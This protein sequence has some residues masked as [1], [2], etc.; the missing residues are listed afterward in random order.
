MGLSA[1]QTRLLHYVLQKPS[2]PNIPLPKD[3]VNGEN[4]ENGNDSE[5]TNISPED[6]LKIMDKIAKSY[7]Q[8][9][10]S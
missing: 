9:G 10:I 3:E 8:F 2:K 6:I 4:L 1:S 7:N 5:N